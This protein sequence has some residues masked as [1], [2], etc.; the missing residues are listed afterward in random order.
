ME[1]R[2]ISK[3]FQARPNCLVAT[4]SV[5]RGRIAKRSE[6]SARATLDLRPSSAIARANIRSGSI[7][8]SESASHGH[9][10]DPQT[11][12]LSTIIEG[13]TENVELKPIQPS[14][15]NV[16]QLEETNDKC[17]AKYRS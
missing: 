3:I 17:T 2:E 13:T 8:D 11:W 10:R 1:K 9:P 14:L 7:N 16:R 5:E 15:A 4:Y 12:K 6:R